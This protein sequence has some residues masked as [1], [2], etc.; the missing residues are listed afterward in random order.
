LTRL[1]RPGEHEPLAEVAWDEERVRAAIREIASDTEAAFH[2]E[3][4][5]AAHPRDDPEPLEAPWTT[6]YL[7]AIGVVW[8]LDYLARE[9]A[10]QLSEEYDAPAL[11]ERYLS[12]P[13]FGE[14]RPSYYV[15]EAGLLTVSS[16][17]APS[18]KTAHLLERAIR[19][20][21]ANPVN[22]ALWGAPGTML[23]ALFLLDWT[24]DPR[25]RDAYLE[26]ADTLWER[27]R[28]EPQSGCHLWTQELHGRVGIQ[29]GPVHGFAGNALALLRGE[30]LLE[31]ERR[32][33]L[34]GRCVETL[35]Q[36]AQR[37]DGLANWLPSEDPTSRNWSEV[38]VQFCHG[39]PGMIVA[40]AGLGPDASELLLTGGELT[41][42]AGPLAK[43]PG[44]CHGTAGNG[45]AFLKLYRRTGDRVWLERARAFA[46]HAIEQVRAERDRV[47]RGR[48]SLWTGDPGV[49]LYLWHCV[50]EQAE[51][52]SLELL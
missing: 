15:G 41:W 29:L 44:L 5:W 14:V 34:H 35:R 19:S 27:W 47:G 9:G 16:R 37:E 7:G 42:L 51:F 48:Y 36:T 21:A 31:T 33:E 25:W 6:L 4:L 22:E 45:Y 32:A 30:T 26:S 20:N 17:L 13:D 18:E 43:G 12:A 1:Y 11:H 40:L 46:M 28:F 10:I 38:R 50:T 49:A 2:P 52:P 8:A 24:G 39:A 3:T 23:A